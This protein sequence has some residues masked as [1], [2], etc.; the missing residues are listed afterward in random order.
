MV[1]T[2]KAIDLADFAYRDRSDGSKT[3]LASTFVGDLR[4]GRPRRR[5]LKYRL[6]KNAHLPPDV[7]DVVDTRSAMTSTTYKARDGLLGKPAARDYEDA[8]M[9]RSSSSPATPVKALGTTR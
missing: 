2:G 8:F 6:L 7:V 4:H 3:I 5:T 1:L 9:P